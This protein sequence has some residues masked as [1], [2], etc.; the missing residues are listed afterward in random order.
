MVTV[1]DADAATV[2]PERVTVV[3]NGVDT[4]RF[5]PTP[6]PAA[7]RLVFTGAL[8]TGAN[9]DGIGWFCDEVLPLVRTAVHGA[10]LDVVG[11]RPSAA[12]RALDRRP[13]IAVHPDVA[14]VVPYLQAARVALVPLRVGSGSRLKALEA[15]AA[16][17]PV[18]G[19]RI[20]LEG[21][22]Y[23][24]DVH[25]SVA[26]DPTDLARLVVELLTDDAKAARQA[27]AAH[28]LVVDRYSWSTIGRDYVA[29][30]FGRIPGPPSGRPARWPRS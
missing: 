25:A 10:T 1:S 12:V 27:E 14:S 20:G 22:V 3:P 6:L 26:D 7:H 13:G 23:R 24:P 5:V 30:L 15:M 17:R 18:A 8:Y 2:G 19:T 11:L 29:S 21:L 9:A 28:R 4:S 16:G